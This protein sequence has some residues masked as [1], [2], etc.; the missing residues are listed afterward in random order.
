MN[1]KLK[2]HDLKKKIK[3]WGKDIG[4]NA[5]G[6][7]DTDLGAQKKNYHAWLKNDFHG[8][9]GFLEKHKELKFYPK[10]L[11]QGTETIISCRLDYLPMQENML[12]A[13][14]KK[15]QAYISR[16]AL[17]RDYHKV[18]KKKLKQL[19]Q[20]IETE[21][22]DPTLKMRIFT[23]SAPVLEVEIANK[24]GLGWRGKHTLL[25]NR[26][27]GS[28]FFLG[29]IYISLN[30]P[31]DTPASAHCG[32][33]SACIDICPTKAIIAPYKLDARR[34]IS[35]LTI[36]HKSSIPLE[37]RK[38][39]GNRIYGCDD[40]Q[41]ICPWNKYSQI[42]KEQDFHVRN[43][44]HQLSLEECFKMSEE[45]FKQL[46]AGSAIYRIGHERWLRNVAVALGNIQKSKTILEL[47]K[48]RLT[49][50]STMVKEHILWAIEQ[51]K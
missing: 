45:E 4:F 46:F 32:S 28:W 47:L 20:K 6:I 35:Y 7:A 49:H 5:I 23:D 10:Q 17:G 51:H 9:M 24:S 38:A 44:L 26:E 43:N 22:N 40:C 42:T 12:Q 3:L 29:E 34:C 37:F 27:H 33:C 21:V 8:E 25:L 39:I 16:Y 36:E 50:S 2:L 13:L 14:R 30:L 19:C 15:K 1:D 11:F 41:I 18:L 48:S 31:V